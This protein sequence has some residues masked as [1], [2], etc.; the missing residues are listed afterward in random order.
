MIEN[1]LPVNRRHDNF[2]ERFMEQRTQKLSNFE[3]PSMENSLPFPIEPLR[4]ALATLPQKRVSNTSTDC[5]VNFPLVLSPAMPKTPDKL[6]PYLVPS[7]SRMN[8]HSGPL[9]PV[10]QFTDISRKS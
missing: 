7:T 10:E 3:Q 9:T 4:T 2:Y 8:L 5:G 6:Q 1:Y